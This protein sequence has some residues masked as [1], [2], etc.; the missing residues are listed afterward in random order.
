[1]L[2]IPPDLAWTLVAGGEIMQ[3]TYGSWSW[4]VKEASALPSGVREIASA[5]MVHPNWITKL[6]RV[7]D[8]QSFCE[9]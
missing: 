7:V 9:K 5:I 8:S 4:P 3:R 1:M 2:M 6:G